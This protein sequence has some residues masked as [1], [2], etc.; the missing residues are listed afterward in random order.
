VSDP[1]RDPNEALHRRVEALEA[2]RD[3]LRARLDAARRG[4]EPRPRRSRANLIAAVAALAV[5]GLAAGTWVA[6]RASAPPDAPATPSY[7]TG[8]QSVAPPSPSAN[9]LAHVLGLSVVVYPSTNDLHAVSSDARDTF[10]GGDRGELAQGNVLF[11][12][13][14]KKLFENVDA[15]ASTTIRALTREKPIIAVGDHG[16]VLEVETKGATAVASGTKSDL[17]GVARAGRVV[18]AVGQKGAVVRY[19]AEWG[20]WRAMDSGTTKDLYAVA[21]STDGESLV[22]VGEGGLVLAMR[23]RL[24]APAASWVVEK[25]PT[26]ED[27]R[28]VAADGDTMVAV[29]RRGTILRGAATGAWTAETSGVTADLNAVG[30]ADLAGVKRTIAVGQRGIAIVRDPRSGAWTT[31]T[32]LTGEDLFAINDRPL[33]V[34]GAKGTFLG[35]AGFWLEQAR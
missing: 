3:E 30:V 21:T 22:A 34:V 23:Q 29:G 19:A 31:H 35:G 6:L 7:P 32:F 5:A 9:G 20:A 14:H 12:F 1:F 33:L 24:G 17:F 13:A 26:T 16:L 25:T 10:V 8:G 15:G 27:L 2:E 28:A 18:Y 11:A 4:V